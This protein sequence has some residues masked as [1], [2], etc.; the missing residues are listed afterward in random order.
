MIILTDILWKRKF[1]L[2]VIAEKIPFLALSVVF[3]LVALKAQQS[4]SAL[5]YGMVNDSENYLYGFY[6]YISYLQKA[7]YPGVLSGV[8]PYGSTSHALLYTCTVLF[9]LFIGGSY[10]LYRKTGL[11]TLFGLAFFV[12]T[13]SIVVKFIPV[14]E[15]L[16]GERYSYIPY[17]GLFL[18]IAMF[19]SWLL[20]NP[21]YKTAGIAALSVYLLIL[22]IPGFMYLLTYKN[23]ETYWLNTIKAY[24]TY[25][26]AHYVLALHY[27]DTGQ[28]DTGQIDTGQIEKAI[29]HNTQAINLLE[30]GFPKEMANL[31]YNRASIY[32]NKMSDFSRAADDY[33][34]VLKYDSTMKEPD[35]TMKNACFFLGYC[36]VKLDRSGE[37]YPFLKHYVALD[38]TNAKAYYFL[39]LAN[40]GLNQH[41]DAFDNLGRAIRLDPGFSDA[42]LQRSIVCID[43]LDRPKDALND[44][45]LL[46]NQGYMLKVVYFNLANCNFHLGQNAEVIKYCDLAIGQGAEKGTAQFLKALSYEKMRQYRD[47]FTCGQAARDAGY[48]VD[49]NLLRKWK[50]A[51]G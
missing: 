22:V 35:S 5:S 29:D 25:Y 49:D 32:V 45:R 40:R 42:Y 34:Q 12:V 17:I 1:N 48:K 20:Q 10:W 2:I 24:P 51:A 16:L 21:K 30:P 6:N 8:H 19:F 23:S 18:L 41:Q 38:S 4:V 7:I 44:L 9:F 13:I 43:Y 46:V 15:A 36:Y 27:N 39:A 47:A 37:G 11:L 14:G 50:S 33:R 28:N 26:R 3:G 31:Y